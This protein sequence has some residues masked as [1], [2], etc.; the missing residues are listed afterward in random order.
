MSLR[1]MEDDL[2]SESSPQDRIG[3]MALAWARV[4]SPSAPAVS[5]RR[6]GGRLAMRGYV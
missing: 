2:C 6:R 3:G 1:E 5:L 4:S